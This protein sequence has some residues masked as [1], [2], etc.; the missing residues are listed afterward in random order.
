MTQILYDSNC[1]KRM[2]NKSMSIFGLFLI[3]VTFLFSFAFSSV[4]VNAFPSKED[5]NAKIKAGKADEALKLLDD[6]F[7]EEGG[8]SNAVW[9]FEKEIG[10][11]SF[12]KGAQKVL[13][14]NATTDAQGEEESLL[15][16]AWKLI[17]NVAQGIKVIGFLF[18]SLF[19]VL[20]LIETSTRGSY[21]PDIFLRSLIKF[22]IALIC[23]ENSVTIMA[24]IVNFGA[25]FY[26]LVE[27]TQTTGAIASLYDVAKKVDDAN[28]L[29]LLGMLCSDLLPYL[30]MWVANVFISI[31]TI[32]R[33]I[34]LG[35]RVAFAPIG[36]ADMYEGGTKSN[37]FR[38]MKKILALSVQGALILFCLGLYGVLITKMDTGDILNKIALTLAT[39]TIT[40]KTQSF[41]NDLFGA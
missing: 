1:F 39:V 37:G 29:D 40:I 33:V 5:F 38:Y 22:F 10:G 19:F 3:I 14:L 18:V 13:R 6:Y 15:Q 9:G 12:G 7:D 34:E 16:S 36:M 27:S 35:I 26:D 24:T 25:V 20:E 32:G 4:T 21:T 31:I 11:A 8:L 28:I 2:L 41:A 23:I 30:A 17:K